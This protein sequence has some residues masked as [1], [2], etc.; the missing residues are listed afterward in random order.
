MFFLGM[1]TAAVVPTRGIA[2]TKTSIITS[3]AAVMSGVQ[4]APSYDGLGRHERTMARKADRAGRDRM[5]GHCPV[6]LWP[7][8]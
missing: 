3:G 6:P 8:S 1:S 4:E 5:R 2:Q 7:P